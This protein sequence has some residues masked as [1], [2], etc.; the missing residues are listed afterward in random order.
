M[1]CTEYAT[2]CILCVSNESRIVDTQVGKHTVLAHL[3]GS[4]ATKCAA[5]RLGA[6]RID[7]LRNGRLARPERVDARRD[8]GNFLGGQ[9]VLQL[10]QLALKILQ[11]DLPIIVTHLDLMNRNVA[12]DLGDA[13]RL[14]L[15]ERADAG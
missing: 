6:E 5:R 1:S 2:M 13:L 12:H 3:R 7:T 9:H 11:S 4:V 15:E 10:A 14:G 8:L